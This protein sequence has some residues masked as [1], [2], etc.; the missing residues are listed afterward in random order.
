M[1]GCTRMS[2]KELCETDDLATSL[3]LDPLLGFSTHKMNISPVPEVRRWGNLKETLLRFQRIHDFQATFEALTVGELAGDYFSE[4][5]A[6][7][8]E[9]LR[10]HVYRYLGAFL[11]DSGVRIESCD[12]YSSETNGARITSTRHWYIG[13]RVEVLLGCIAELSPADSAVLRAGVNDFSVMYSTRKRCAQLWLGPAA[14][15]NHDCR[16]NCKFVPGEKNGACVEVIRPIA[17]GDEITCYYGASFFGEGNEMCEC[18]T[19]ERKGEGHFKHRGKLPD[20]EETKECGS[21]AYRLRER[22]LVQKRGPARPAFLGSHSA[23]PSRN[24]F[25]QQMRRNAL[26]SKKLTQTKNWRKAKHRRSEKKQFS[27]SS[28][29]HDWSVLSSQI[30]LKELRIR[31]QRHTVDFLLHCKDPKS[32][33]RALLL[34]LEEVKPKDNHTKLDSINDTQAS[35]EKANSSVSVRTLGEVNLK[36]FTL[37]SSGSSQDN[38]STV[39]GISVSPLTV[40]DTPVVRPKMTTRT[41]SMIQNSCRIETGL[42][43]TKDQ[44]P[45]CLPKDIDK[46]NKANVHKQKK[47]D[48]NVTKT[49]SV[50]LDD[51]STG[52]STGSHTI[53]ETCTAVKDHRPPR[54]VTQQIEQKATRSVSLANKTIQTNKHTGEV[55]GVLQSVPDKLVKNVGGKLPTLKKYV[56]VN[57]TRMKLPQSIEVEKDSDENEGLM[58]KGK[59]RT[60]PSDR[61]LRIRPTTLTAQADAVVSVQKRGPEQTQ[62]VSSEVSTTDGKRDV[63]TAAGKRGVR[64][65]YFKP[66]DNV[67]LRNRWAPEPVNGPPCREEMADDKVIAIQ[68]ASGKEEGQVEKDVVEKGSEELVKTV[69]SSKISVVEANSKSIQR[70]GEESESN[71]EASGGNSSGNTREATDEKERVTSSQIVEDAIRKSASWEKQDIAI[72]QARV[73]LT[74]ILKKVRSEKDKKSEVGIVRTEI[75]TS[76][77]KGHGDVTQN[78]EIS[79]Q[80]PCQLQGDRDSR[81]VQKRH[82]RNLRTRPKQLVNTSENKEKADKLPNKEDD[83]KNELEVNQDSLQRLLKKKKSELAKSSDLLPPQQKSPTLSKSNVHPDSSSQTQSNIPLKKR[84]F[85]NSV[86]L[87]SEQTT[88]SPPSDQTTI[89]PPSDQVSKE[90]TELNSPTEQALDTPDC[91]VGSGNVI[92]ESKVR[93]RKGEAQKLTGW[94]AKQNFFVKG[95]RYKALEIHQTRMLRNMN[96]MVKVEKK[97]GDGVDHGLTHTEDK[98]DDK[99]FKPNHENNQNPNTGTED[100]DNSSLPTGMDK[101]MEQFKIRFKRKRGRVWEMEKLK[102]E[103]W[104]LEKLKRGD[105]PTCDPFKAIMDSVSVLNMEMEAAQAH[106]KASIRSKD[107]LH[108]LKKRAQRLIKSQANVFSTS[109]NSDPSQVLDSKT[110]TVESKDDLNAQV[111][112]DNQQLEKCTINR[113]AIE[114]TLFVGQKTKTEDHIIKSS[115]RFES[116]LKPKLKLEGILLPRIKLRRKDDDIWE[117]E[118]HDE[119]ELETKPKVERQAKQDCMDNCPGLGK[120]KDS[121]VK[122]KE[123]SPHFSLSL[124]PL[125]LYSPVNDSAA[126]Q[127]TVSSP[128]RMMERSVAEMSSVGRRPRHRVERTRQSTTIETPTTSCLSHTLQQI[129]NSLSRLS[130]GLCESQALEKTACL[131]ASASVIQPLSHSPPFSS[132]DS[133]FTN[134]PSFS[135][136]CDDDL[137]DFQCLNFEG[138]YHTQECLPTSPSDLCPLDPPTDP[139]SSPLSHSPSDAWDAE[140]PYLGSPSPGNN[141]NSEDLPFLPNLVSSKGDCVPLDYTVKDNP[142]DK[143]PLNSNF[144][145]PSLSSSEAA[146]MDRFLNKNPG[147]RSLSKEETKAHPMT[148]GSKPQPFGEGLIT[149]TS[150]SQMN[151][152]NPSS[153]GANFKTIASTGQPR[154]LSHL[155]SQ[156]PFHRVNIPNKPKIFPMNQHNAAPQSCSTKSV[157]SHQS[158]NKFL[159]SQLFNVKN[160]TPTDNLFNLQDKNSSV[161]HRVKYQGGKQTL[162]SAPC[163]DNVAIGSPP[164][165]FKRLSDREK[166]QH[167]DKAGA[168]TDYCKGNFVSQGFTSDK[169]VVHHYNSNNPVMTNSHSNQGNSVFTQSFMKSRTLS[170]K[171][172]SIENNFVHTNFATLPRPFFFPSKVPESYGPTQGKNLIGDRSQ[173]LAPDKHQQSY[174]QHDP[175]DF[176]HGPPVSPSLFQHNMHQVSHSALPG[177]PASANKN[178]SS[179]STPFPQAYHGHPYV[180]NFSGDHS[181]TLGLR[182]GAESLTCSGLGPT[183]YTYHCLMEPSGTQ[184]RLVLEPCGPQLSNAAPFP[185]GAMSGFK[186]HE[187]SCKKDTQPQGHP[188]DHPSTSHYGPSTSSHSMGSTKPKRVR[189]VV[190]DGTVDLDLQ[191]SD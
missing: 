164:A 4:L 40:V 147:T 5:G 24:S 87:D 128:D 176:T 21:Q 17:P 73:L 168:S 155:R 136:C 101:E 116:E 137:L 7:R 67:D 161:I 88:S 32:K 28:A 80:E 84:M 22:R 23:I 115:C 25:T 144:S 81:T 163:K 108:H 190:T 146:A 142:R 175:F 172:Q 110:A 49:Q 159:S 77:H 34:I 129:D 177:T 20:C 19:C 180:L 9:L 141:F 119:T 135:N 107:N 145:F 122:L 178:Q 96:K 173:T 97:E 160:P 183:N 57:L 42:G 10:Q 52:S 151:Q 104:S 127:A 189:L 162:C 70:E 156:G 149:A 138:Y 121:T 13:E 3:V 170:D 133:M 50:S 117:V 31:V 102:H 157:Y 11:L 6:H 126:A 131:S 165:M 181:L 43:N 118:S 44:V 64:E 48:N 54:P 148:Q 61:I 8:Q 47:M 123:E 76:I 72:K 37:D 86:D 89:S 79:D 158:A 46:I 152:S 83:A 93:Q 113:N 33:E 2:V 112:M 124:S 94:A 132:Q 16:P 111:F 153:Q 12:R 59:I 15:I 143:M 95:L 139:F 179:P 98:Q 26:I 18:C 174:A 68:Q 185:P 30:K 106:V 82:L 78:I 166:N 53:N 103:K 182:D 60:P 85:R 171:P 109:L 45:V 169:G 41:R 62:A 38:G 191:Y 134:D 188:G 92:R 71:T 51:H 56:T 125:S 99:T 66:I 140:T 75:P 187:D 91:T 69:D 74:D 1:D 36:P 167:G 184:G 154:S 105:S 14:F 63:S 186:S 114:T 29:K 58:E 55:M 27:P 120:E 130:E 39:T 65:M 150:Q 35:N 100:G 90:G